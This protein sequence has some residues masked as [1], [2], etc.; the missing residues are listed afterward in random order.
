MLVF[1]LGCIVAA[2]HLAAPGAQLVDVQR[3]WDKAPHNAFTD[4]VWHRGAWFCVFREGRGHVSDDGALR[5]LRSEDGKSWTS[6][7]L[8]TS[9]DAD[10]RDAKIGVTPGG[11]LMLTG[12]GAM[13]QPADARHR[14]MAW[15][16]DDG[17]TWSDPVLIAEK[18]WWLWRVTWHGDT[19]YGVAYATDGRETTRLYR[20]G[21]G[22]HFS[23]L[24][25][26]LFSK[27]QDG[28]GGPDEASLIF[29]ED[30]TCLCLLRRDGDTKS[31]QLGTAH[32]PYTDWTWKDLGIYVGGPQLLPLPDGRIVAAGR[33]ITTGSAR[34]VLYWLD[35]EAGTLTEFLV[36]PSGG[37]CSY[38]GLAWHD[39]L[40]WVSYYSSHEGKT[41]IYLAR[42]QP[43]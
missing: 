5:V 33:S 42:V 12:A 15:F 7:A 23:T 40:L 37:D 18:N 43:G 39:G 34:T 13:H 11:R 21:D 25:P 28:K 16:S 4:L 1:E 35:P 2:C 8:I 41:A 26:E 10:L 22:K 29:L 38:P 9:D 14:S 24:V 36:L 20:S 6:S 19:C 27:E 3:I 32:P 17:A 31:A 30:D